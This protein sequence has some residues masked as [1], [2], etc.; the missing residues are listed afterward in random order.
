[1]TRTRLVLAS[2]VALVALAAAPAA[3]AAPPAV[4][5]LDENS[6]TGESKTDNYTNDTTPTFQIDAGIAN[7]GQTLTLCILESNTTGLPTP[8]GSGIVPV[9]GSVE[10]TA[11]P[12]LL[13]ATYKVSAHVDS[14]ETCNNSSGE[15]SD[16]YLFLVVD[17]QAPTLTVAPQLLTIN[18]ADDET[19]YSATPRFAV[20]A[21]TNSNVVLYDGSTAHGSAKSVAGIANVTVTPPLGDG[22]HTIGA[23]AT[24]LAGNESGLSPTTTF[25]VDATAPAVSTPD[26]LDDDGDSASDNYTSFPRPRFAIATESGAVATLYENGIALG[27][28]VAT[29]G[30]ATVQ[31]REALW[32]DPGTHCVYAVAVDAVGNP[33]AGSSELCITVA[34]GVPPF[35]SNLGVTLA[36]EWLSLRLSSSVAATVRIRVLRNGKVVVKAKRAVRAGNRTKVGLHLP[37]RARAARKLVVVA[38]LRSADGR[39]I[40][41]R[42]VVRRHA[43]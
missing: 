33:S 34:P 35:T 26:L 14:S 38:T 9:N 30:V 20:F 28:A 41:V 12:A 27:S 18:G 23:K 6:D 19:T 17:T 29:G 13:D 32:L 43:R 24:D 2:L 16:G 36:G 22:T 25:K 8:Y 4:P 5:D 40:E 10:I 3:L 15:S 21:E 31:V 39:R 37:K 7:A 1:M 11:A 42:R